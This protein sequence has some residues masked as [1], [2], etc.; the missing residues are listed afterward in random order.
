[1]QSGWV[2]FFKFVF[3]PLVDEPQ[4]F[5]VDFPLA[6]DFACCSSVFVAE[7][8]NEQEINSVGS[9]TTP[10]IG[11]N[12]LTLFSKSI[13]KCQRFLYSCK[14]DGLQQQQRQ[15]QQKAACQKSNV[16]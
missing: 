14:C 5:I 12:S 6:R 3:D 11:T 13:F 9:H 8:A 10:S 1:M 4:A 15:Q 2:R 16:I 7:V